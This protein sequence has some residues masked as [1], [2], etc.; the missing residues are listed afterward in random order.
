MA[1]LFNVEIDTADFERKLTE[2]GVK[3]AKKVIKAAVING[4]R[5]LQQSVITH[6]PERTD[7]VQGGNALPPGALKADIHMDVHMIPEKESAV[8]RVG[9]GKDTKYVGW[10]L[11]EGHNIT[12]RGG[13]R[14]GRKVIGHVPPHKFMVPAF[15]AAS[16]EALAAV[17]D[18]IMEAVAEEESAEP[19]Q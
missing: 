3:M 16:N 15:D 2:L 13:S 11:E 8:V 6:A 10:F 12:T 1:D 7:N 19:N 4:G 18:T 5:V 9:P 14:K 17:T